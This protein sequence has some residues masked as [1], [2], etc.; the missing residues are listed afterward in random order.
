MLSIEKMPFYL[1]FKRSLWQIL[2][3]GGVGGSW[4]GRGQHKVRVIIRQ[5]RI[6]NLARLVIRK[7]WARVG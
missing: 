2:V 7:V 3:A 4:N 6:L 1:C 5:K